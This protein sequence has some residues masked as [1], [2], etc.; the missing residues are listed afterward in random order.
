[1]YLFAQKAITNR[2]NNRTYVLT[3][4]TILDSIKALCDNAKSYH[5]VI[6]VGLKVPTFVRWFFI[7]VALHT[8]MNDQSRY[9]F[10]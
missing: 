3:A 10:H 1:M 6:D 4:I 9:L 2:S 7:P 8:S 5:S